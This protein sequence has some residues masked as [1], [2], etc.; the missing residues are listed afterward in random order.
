MPKPSSAASNKKTGAAPVVPV[1][2]E[3][4]IESFEAEVDEELAVLNEIYPGDVTMTSHADGWGKPFRTLVTTVSAGSEDDFTR[5]EARVSAVSVHATPHACT[6][7]LT[8]H[9]HSCL[10]TRRAVHVPNDRSI[11]VSA[12]NTSTR[13]PLTPSCTHMHAMLCTCKQQ[14]DGT[15]LCTHTHTHTHTHTCT[16]RTITHKPS[17]AGACTTM[18]VPPCLYHHAPPLNRLSLSS[19]RDIQRQ[20]P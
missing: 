7:S 20:N 10:V 16:T 13:S 11:V 8:R 4:P 9:V 14:P 17:D 3:V 1:V 19:T 18:P 5:I 15:L 6:C 12:G 2:P